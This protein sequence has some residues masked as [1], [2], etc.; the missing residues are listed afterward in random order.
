MTP[1]AHLPP[2]TTVPRPAPPCRSAWTASPLPTLL[3]IANAILDPA[4]QAARCV[5]RSPEKALAAGLAVLGTLKSVAANPLDGRPG[6]GAVP[7]GAGRTIG[8]DIDACIHERHIPDLDPRDTEA[9]CLGEIAYGQ[10][11]GRRFEPDVF[12]EL[13]RREVPM[14]S[15]A[16]RYVALVKRGMHE[17]VPLPSADTPERNVADAAKLVVKVPGVQRRVDA[18]A[19]ALVDDCDLRE[20]VDNDDLGVRGL[21][22]RADAEEVLHSEAC[23]AEGLQVPT[24]LELRRA[25]AAQFYQSGKVGDRQAFRRGQYAIHGGEGRDAANAAYADAVIDRIVER[26]GL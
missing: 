12:R 21:F 23:A 17:A 24:T 25:N 5:L 4:M 18:D 13:G 10:A 7:R 9:H 19:A 8:E 15:D 26:V 22:I 16:G 3:R 14:G 1:A 20:R 6:P 2:T 11:T